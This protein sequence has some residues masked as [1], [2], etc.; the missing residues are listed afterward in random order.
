MFIVDS[1]VVCLRAEVINDRARYEAFAKTWLCYLELSI[2][3]TKSKIGRYLERRE[4]FRASSAEDH[5]GRSPRADRTVYASTCNTHRYAKTRR[6]NLGAA[7][8]CGARK[9]HGMSSNLKATP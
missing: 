8:E 3:L 5:P 6:K 9:R 7:V 2:A 4:F 1:E